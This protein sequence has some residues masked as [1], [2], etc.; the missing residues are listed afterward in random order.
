MRSHPA[1]TATVG[2]VPRLP[3]FVDAGDGVA[4]RR[5]IPAD[6]SGLFVIHSDPAVYRFDPGLRHDD[7]AYT[8]SWLDRIM[9]DWDRDGL[10]YWTVLV[11]QSWW[12]AAPRAARDGDRYIAGEAGIRWYDMLGDAVLNVYFRMAPAV[13]G[14]GLAG[15]VVALADD[16]A[17]RELP[18]TDLVIRTHQDNAAA[19]RVAL[20]AGFVAEGPSPEGDGLEV[21]RRAGTT[22]DVTPRE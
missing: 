18:T 13:Q 19:A 14:R 12:P 1:A 7:I 10:G 15:R 9:A 22:G 11:P 16:W 5:P 17:S 8:S 4:V 20:R 2:G 21:F 3:E 6:V